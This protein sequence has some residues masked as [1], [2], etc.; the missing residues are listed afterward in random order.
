MWQHWRRR[1]PVV[2]VKRISRKGVKINLRRIMQEYKKLFYYK[3]TNTH[4]IVFQIPI[5]NE[6]EK[7]SRRA[8]ER[9]EKHKQTQ[10]IDGIE[11]GNKNNITKRYKHD[12]VFINNQC[13]N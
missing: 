10:N 3:Y 2:F 1:Q 7:S 8:R 9:W 13:L 11:R 6:Y 4:Q 5:E 12:L